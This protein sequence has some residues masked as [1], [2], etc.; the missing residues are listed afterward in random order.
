MAVTPSMDELK[1]LGW[2]AF[3]TFVQCLAGMGAAVV[4]ATSTGHVDV[5]ALASAGIIAAGAGVAAV[6]S[7][8]KTFASQRIGTASTSRPA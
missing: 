5:H 2:R 6:F 1:D 8:V 3:W 4:M 7:L